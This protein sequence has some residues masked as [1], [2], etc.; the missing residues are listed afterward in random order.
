MNNSILQE[1]LTL[2]F[3]PADD[4]T[5]VDKLKKSIEQLE[6]KLLKEKNKIIQFTLVAL[7]PNTSTDEPVLLEVQDLVIKNWPVY[8]NKAGGDNLVT[9]NRAV[10]L[11]ALDNLANDIQLAG[12]IWLTGRNVIK[13]YNLGREETI[14]KTWLKKIGHKYEIS[15]R[16]IWGLSA[17]QESSK[18]AGE[19]IEELPAININK[20][21]LKTKLLAAAGPTYTNEQG[22]NIASE[23]PNLN[24]PESNG[25]WVT[26]FGN[27]ASDAI[28]NIITSSI[29]ANN[30]EIL[31]FFFRQSTSFSTKSLSLDLR[32]QLLW[33]KESQYSPSF[34]MSYRD[35]DKSILPFV[36]SKDLVDIIPTIYPQSV[37]YFAMEISRVSDTETDKE[38]II[39]DIPP[40]I[41]NKNSLESVF[42]PYTE[43]NGRSSLYSFILSLFHNKTTITEAENTIG[44]SK[45]TSMKKSEFLIWL[46]HDIQAI[47]LANTK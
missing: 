39:G 10:I 7:D 42:L 41:K 17:F 32:N 2:Q 46:L 40:M 19:A 37:D 4:E 18:K 5:V 1:Y 13:Y 8:V 47:K 9:Y 26:S 27:L 3:I 36:I 23:N 33:L 6:K 44:L 35:I 22:E 11:S 43:I 38:I 12:I 20:S 34:E 24:W 28:A 16:Q 21:G 30:K 14:L 45:K 31:N 29:K 25:P 15:A